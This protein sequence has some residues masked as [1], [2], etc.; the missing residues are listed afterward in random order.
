VKLVSRM[1]LELKDK[2]D[3]ARGAPSSGVVGKPRPQQAFDGQLGTVHAALVQMGFRALE[4]EQAVLKIGP[5]ADGKQ[6]E[7]LLREALSVLA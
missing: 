4:A 6:T 1:V 2:L 5:Q 7:Q 3:F